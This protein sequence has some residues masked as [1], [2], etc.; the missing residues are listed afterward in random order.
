MSTAQVYKK[1]SF[2][3]SE[4][5]AVFQA[6]KQICIYCRNLV[7]WRDFEVDH[8][9]N[10]SLLKEP[11]KLAALARDYELESGFDINSFRNWACSHHSCNRTKADTTFDKSRALHYLLIA[12]KKAKSAEGIYQ[13]T[14]RANRA[15][16]VLAHLRALI[17]NG[18]LSRQDVID[19]ANAIV[20][21]ADIGINNPVVIC[22]SLR[23][24]DVYE[25]L[26]ENVPD[27]PPYIYDWLESELTRELQEQL[28][29]TLKQ[30][31]D[32]RNGETVSARYAFWDLDLNKLNSLKLQWWEVL[33][34]ALHTEIYGEFVQKD[35]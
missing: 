14:E 19:F 3:F 16:K 28:Q 5:W 1:Y 7:E 15:N 4:R 13:A 33:E 27:S 11:D 25:N 31:E 34:L 17:E 22:F 24:E 8:I 30:W 29:C 18:T 20:R 6:Y 10:E 32:E 23:M 21:N 35:D 12:G 2:S 26:P 9:L